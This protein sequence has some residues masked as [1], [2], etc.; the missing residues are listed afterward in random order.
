M[1]LKDDESTV[2]LLRVIVALMLRPA[3]ERPTTLRQ[4]IEILDGLALKP[5]E[6]ANILCRSNTY[7]SKELAGI[8]KGRS[9]KK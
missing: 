6:I 9:K 8:R 3:D 5:A 7:V 1:V 2:K 4:Q